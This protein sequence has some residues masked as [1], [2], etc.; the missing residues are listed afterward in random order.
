MKR[1]LSVLVAGAAC[2]ASAQAITVGVDQGPAGYLGYMNVFE[3]PANGG[4]FVFGSGWG[5]ADLNASFDNGASTLTLSPNTIGDPNPFW[6]TPSGG[7]G[8]AGNK[9]MQA[10]LYHEVTGSMSGMSV[11]FEGVVLSNTFTSAHVARIFIRDFAADYSSSVDTYIPLVAGNFS[12]T[13]FTIPGA[14]RHVQWGF[15]VEGVNVWA[16]DTGPYG[17]AVIATIPAPAS[18]GLMGLGGLAMARR[19]RA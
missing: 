8:A 12:I 11:T 2:A 7:P 19:R 17:T 18:L 10:N 9:I 6:Y 5:V 13:Q 3:L 16:T 14:G 4:G 1:M 15:Q